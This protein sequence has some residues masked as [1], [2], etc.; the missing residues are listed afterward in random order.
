MDANVCM[1]VIIG[2][3]K[4]QCHRKEGDR[5]TDIINLFVQWVKLSIDYLFIEQR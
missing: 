5:Q 4:C 2:V 1:C 3:Y